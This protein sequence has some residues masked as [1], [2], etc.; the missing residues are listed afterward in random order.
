MSKGSFDNSV[1]VYCDMITDGGGWTVIQRNKKN[2]LVNFN[3]NWAE[4]E[5]GFGDLTT[6][7]WYG[8][9]A[10]HCLTQRGQW[11]MRVDYQFNNKTSTTIS[12][13]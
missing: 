3:R 9:S 8:L 2:S 13:V 1:N 10:I 11:E 5:E 6:E 4:Y 7:F 12:S